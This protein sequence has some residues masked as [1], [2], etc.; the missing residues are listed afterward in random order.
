MDV[1][2]RLTAW[3]PSMAEY[4]A[5]H[6][7]SA[8][9]LRDVDREGLSVAFWRRAGQQL[10]ARA[11]PGGRPLTTERALALG[12]LMHR[13]LFG[14]TSTV[15]EAAPPQVLARRGKLWEAAKAAAERRGADA[16]L[17]A[18]EMAAAAESWASLWGE[19]LPL[20]QGT[21]IYP[22]TGAKQLIRG[23]LRTW[24]PAVPEVS[25]RWEILPG[26]WGRIREDWCAR[27]PRLWTFAQ[28]KTTRKSI[29]PHR[30]WPYWRREYA[31]GFALYRQGLRN[32]FGDE[33][34]AQ[35]LV[36]ARLA[37]PWQW[38][39]YD[40]ASRADELDELW[41]SKGLPYCVTIKEALD[42]GECWGP[43]ERGI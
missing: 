15:V 26:L 13:N 30:W 1:P 36:V 22:D 23:M 34:F 4:H 42:R 38:V 28:F 25:H 31:L 14:D 35:V 11:H 24:E 6:E 9:F 12:T 3:R 21:P 41:E 20:Q 39:L 37:P 16:L 27:G 2:G 10:K 8:G 7:V 43:E 40:M 5:G 18:H 29:V 33:P 32:L 19:T 17:L